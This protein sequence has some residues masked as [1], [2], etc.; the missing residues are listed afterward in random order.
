MKNWI[1][2]LNKFTKNRI[3]NGLHAIDD[4]RNRFNKGYTSYKK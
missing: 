1:W 2:Q 3:S 4:D